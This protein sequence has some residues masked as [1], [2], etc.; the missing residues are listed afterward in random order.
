M[1]TIT[2]EPE[3]RQAWEH[4]LE[5]AHLDRAIYQRD[6]MVMINCGAEMPG[7]HV[8]SVRLQQPDGVIYGRMEVT[9]KA[10]AQLEGLLGAQLAAGRMQAV[11]TPPLE[12]YYTTGFRARRVLPFT[13]NM[14]QLRQRTGR[15]IR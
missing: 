2:E 9:F 5:Y 13:V 12:D 7:S 8:G 14:G 3:Q 1:P 10:Q 6:Q 11:L 15:R 4:A